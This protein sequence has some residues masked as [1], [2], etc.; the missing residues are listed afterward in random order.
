MVA[1]GGNAERE[2]RSRVQIWQMTSLF[3]NQE[4]E[5]FSLV[6]RGFDPGSLS[7]T[8][9]KWVLHG[10][11]FE[12]LM[13][14]L[15]PEQRKQLRQAH[16]VASVGMEMAIAVVIGTLGGSWLDQR[17]ETRP[18]LA[19]IGMFFGVAAGFRGVLRVAR[20]HERA[21]KVRDE[22]ERARLKKKAKER[23]PSPRARAT[24]PD[25]AEE[26]E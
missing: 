16:R 2:N 12:V 23:P 21:M 17:L 14:F 4:L 11:A 6:S 25:R 15:G 10:G 26:D 3:V 22:R 24:E 1:S 18:W 13:P 19:L 8:P 5:R 7:C 9:D 20:E